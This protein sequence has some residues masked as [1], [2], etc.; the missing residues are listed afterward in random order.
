MG[1][2]PIEKRPIYFGSA[3]RPLF[4]TYHPPIES[5]RAPQAR[6]LGIVLCN[7]IGDELIRAHR[8]LRHLAEALAAGGYPVLRFDFDGTGDSA[9]DER[10]PERVA[11]WRADVRRAVVELR[12]RGGVDQVAL[13]GLKLGGTL[14]A[15]AAEELGGVDALV[16]WGASMTGSAFVAEATKAHKI[17][18]ML[19]P[20]SFSG[21]PP[22]GD[23]HEV[24]GFHLTATTTEDLGSVDLRAL[25]RSPA[26]RTLVIDTANLASAGA[27][28][29][30][31]RGLGGQVSSRHLP[32]QKFLIARPQDAEVPQ[33]AID[34]IVGWLAEDPPAAIRAESPPAVQSEAAHSPSA[35][36]GPLGERGVIFGGARRLFGVLSSPPPD[37]KRPP[38]RCRRSSCSARGPFI[39]S[40]RIGSTCRWRAAGP[41]WGFTC[42]AWTCPASE[43]APPPRAPRRT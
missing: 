22:V 4:G 32:G 31:L 38:P 39:A 12:A 21:G 3:E 2:P 41:R 23:G 8:A 13:V 18:T 36:G 24:L 29:T 35:D 26:R 10:D 28:V 9:G 11:T 19:E 1:S 15:L 20:Q 14:A 5:G 7:P 37:G 34:M 17:H 33:A 30:H 6:P 40:A 27:V 43:T 25:S 16:L 42:S